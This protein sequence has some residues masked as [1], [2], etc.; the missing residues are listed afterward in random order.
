MENTIDHSGL[1]RLGKLT[2]FW[3]LC[4]LFVWF[5]FH[6]LL[7]MFAGLLVAVLFETFA[8]W[9]EEHSP[10]TGML[11]Y[12]ITLL[13]IGG[14]LTGITF[15]LAPGIQKQFVE[16]AHSLPHSIANIEKLLNKTAA[17]HIVVKK[18]D[19]TLSHDHLQPRLAT[20]AKII[21][22][23]LVD[24][25][26]VIVI[27]FFA[28]INPKE[29]QESLL[30][31]FP[32]S[33]RIRIRRIAARVARQLRWWLLGQMV[34]MVVL[35]V[36]SGLSLRLLHVHLPWTL[37]LITGL[38]VFLPYAGTI[39]AGFLSVLMGLENSPQTALWVLILYTLLHV[40]EG[41]ILT[42]VVQHRAVRLPPILTILMQ[43]FLWTVGGVLGLAVAAPLAGAGIVL[44]KELY[45]RQPQVATPD[46]I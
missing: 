13:L 28:A 29:Y 34:P 30:L 2:A 42:P 32:A 43:Y 38:A 36:V 12:A 22:H 3:I 21:S 18:A 7:L 46:N 33:E 44:V 4:F 31:L 27:G 16:V 41:Y 1:V 6:L 45:Y 14:T 20:F 40:T 26:V 11:P 17:G 5:E 37:G 35:G 23:A 19:Q 10:F 15:L 24:L 25:I 9:I 8:S 39:L